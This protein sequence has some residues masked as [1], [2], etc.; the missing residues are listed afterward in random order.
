VRVGQQIL[1]HKFINQWPAAQFTYNQYYTNAYI[2]AAKMNI[3]LQIWTHVKVT[4]V[5]GLW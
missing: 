1:V 3:A 4:R 2:T 5:D